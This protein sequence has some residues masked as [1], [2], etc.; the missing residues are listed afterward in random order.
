MNK[1]KTQNK[2]LETILLCIFGAFLAGFTI[3]FFGFPMTFLFLFVWGTVIVVY[4]VAV[5]PIVTSYLPHQKI[6][7]T[8]KSFLKKCIKCAREIPIASEQCPFCE[9]TQT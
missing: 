9:Q 4:Y 5:K 6:G 1:Q 7:E 3:K 8:P 2:R